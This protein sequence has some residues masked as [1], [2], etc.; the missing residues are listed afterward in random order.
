MYSLPFAI[1][2]EKTSDLIG[3]IE[4][5]FSLDHD[6]LI[7]ARH[8]LNSK[9][10]P[11]VRPEILAYL[12]GFSYSLLLAMSRSPD[13]YYRKYRIRKSGHG[14]RNIEAP[15]RFLKIVQRWIY[16]HILSSVI[17][18]SSVNGFVK[19]KD[20]FSN[21]QPHLS[22]KNI[23]VFDIKNFFPSVKRKMVKNVFKE[24]GFPIKVTTRLTDLCTLDGRLPQGAPTSPAL[25]NTIFSPIDIELL[26]MAEQWE[27]KYTRYADDLVFSGNL[28]FTHRHKLQ[29]K[30]IIVESGFK[31]NTSKTRIIGSGGRQIVAGLVANEKGLPPRFKRMNW[32]ALFHQASLNP[33]KYKGMGLKLMGIAAFVKN[34]SPEIS[35]N[36]KTIAKAVIKSEN[37]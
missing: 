6:E 19:H 16:D 1:S 34:Y 26:N 5:E 13:P 32:R 27:C 35:E 4:E 22:S 9:L 36:Y 24:L 10:P 15:R 21:V 11:L 14:Y 3:T 30:N 29:I 28:K 7:L 8:L 18:P 25:A 2:L 31:I 17:L 20:I 37:N 23:M 33:A 12:F